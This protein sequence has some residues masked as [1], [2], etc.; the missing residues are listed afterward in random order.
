VA[1]VFDNR[2]ACPVGASGTRIACSDRS[3]GR[4]AYEARTLCVHGALWVRVL[5]AMSA[6]DGDGI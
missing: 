5:A 3:D 2:D 1:H 6:V 4:G